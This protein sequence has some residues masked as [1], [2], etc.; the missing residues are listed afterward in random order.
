[1]RNHVILPVCAQ[2]VVTAC[3]WLATEPSHLAAILLGMGAGCLINTAF[4]LH[5]TRPGRR[6]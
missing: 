2:L 4:Y 3:W 1:M 6:K 5:E